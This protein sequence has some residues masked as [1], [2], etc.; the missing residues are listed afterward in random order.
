[1]CPNIRKLQFA[2]NLNHKSA[3]QNIYNYNL[4]TKNTLT[5]I[6]INSS[7]FKEKVSSPFNLY[8]PI[9]HK[10]SFSSLLN[11]DVLYMPTFNPNF[12]NFG[13]VSTLISPTVKQI[14]LRTFNNLK[15]VLCKQLK[16]VGRK[17]FTNLKFLTHFHA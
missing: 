13:V 1:M 15:Y 7:S 17:A 10:S 12:A 6:T 11:R 2:N 3:K 14:N 9:P 4:E 16:K 5:Y 8:K